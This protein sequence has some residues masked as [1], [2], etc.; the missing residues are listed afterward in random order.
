MPSNN[1]LQLTRSARS[2]PFAFRI[3]GQSLRAALA[4]EPGCSTHVGIASRYGT[5]LQFVARRLGA[6][7]LVFVS[8][9]GPAGFTTRATPGTGEQ[10]VLKMFGE[11]EIRDRE[12]SGWIETLA[13]APACLPTSRIKTAWIY[14][15]TFHEDA[16]VFFDASM[17]VACV[18]EGGKL[19]TKAH[20]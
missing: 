13:K 19:F 10:Q 9:C 3:W 5:E 17:K 18:H 2:G 14:Q 6:V 7:L 4:A 20:F 11:P 15:P 16:V 8:A 12:P 1:G